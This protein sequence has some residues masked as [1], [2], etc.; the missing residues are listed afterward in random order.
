MKTLFINGSPNKNGNTKALAEKM[1]KGKAYETLNLTDYRIG[2]Y[3]QNFQD[4][5]LDEVIEQMKQADTIVIGSPLYWH[6]MSGAIRNV[7]DRFY[8]YVDE[9]LLQGKD[10]YF[11]FQ[12]YAPTKEQLAA[13]EYTMSRFAKLYGM[14]YKG[15]ITE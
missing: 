3:G 6:S 2:S 12:G 13:G 5:Q 1:L 10:M 8:G 9:S 15:M 11:V 14:N 4:D 7:L